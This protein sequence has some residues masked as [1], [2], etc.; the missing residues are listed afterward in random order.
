M[1]RAQGQGIRRGD[2]PRLTDWTGTGTGG[3]GGKGSFCF[4]GT[5]KTA[6]TQGADPTAVGEVG[7]GGVE[8]GDGGEEG[9]A[10]VLSVGSRGGRREMESPVG[11]NWRN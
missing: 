6:A 3:R 1:C 8:I 7:W 5:A 10:Q 4:Q 2:D 11:R 9:N